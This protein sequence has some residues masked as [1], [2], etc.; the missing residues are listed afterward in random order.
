LKHFET[1]QQ[2]SFPVITFEVFLRKTAKLPTLTLWTT[3]NIL[4]KYI[5]KISE[6]LRF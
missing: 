5:V 1:G 4:I 2:D 3:S 6:M